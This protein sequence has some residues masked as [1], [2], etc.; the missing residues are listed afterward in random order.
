MEQDI[1]RRTIWFCIFSADKDGGYILAG[2]AWLIKTDANG[3]SNGARH[4]D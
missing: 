2:S 3:I 4:S 1:Q